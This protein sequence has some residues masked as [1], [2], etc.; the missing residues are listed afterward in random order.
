[1][2]GFV[3]L[4]NTD[5]RPVDV[6]VLDR[7]TA[8]MAFRGPDALTRWSDGAVGLGHALL[9]TTD[10]ASPVTQP[11]TL[12]GEVWLAA[13]ARIDRRAELV[14]RIGSL[15]D[16][17]VDDTELVLRAYLKWGDACLDYLR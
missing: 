14:A 9:Q 4:V 3:A 2:S 15:G 7:M 12:D 8:A 16:A 10:D 17:R 13:A 11:F 5:R 6:D 1:M